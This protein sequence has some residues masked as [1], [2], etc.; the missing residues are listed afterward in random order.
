MVSTKKLASGTS[1]DEDSIGD[2]GDI[3]LGRIGVVGFGAVGK[4]MG[5]GSIG[6]TGGR[7]SRLLGS[8]FVWLQT[9][10]STGVKVKRLAVNNRLLKPSFR[11]FWVAEQGIEDFSWLAAREFVD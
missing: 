9:G 1:G 2:E 11:V 10:A 3:D 7:L 8:G 6:L 5:F 4:S